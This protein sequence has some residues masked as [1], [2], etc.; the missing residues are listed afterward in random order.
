MT[1]AERSFTAK[2]IEVMSGGGRSYRILIDD[3]RPASMAL[4]LLA[5]C[6]G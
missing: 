2:A 3:M 4:A 1:P 5:G 6:P